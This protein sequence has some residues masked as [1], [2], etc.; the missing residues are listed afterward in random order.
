M[1]QGFSEGVNVRVREGA[2]ELVGEGMNEGVSGVNER[3]SDV[4]EVVSGGVW[5]EERE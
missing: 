5:E 2:S 3:V 4:N 1:S